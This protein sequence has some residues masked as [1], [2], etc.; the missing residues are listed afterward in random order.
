M[1]NTHAVVL[2]KGITGLFTVTVT[3]GRT[4]SFVSQP[5]GYLNDCYLNQLLTAVSCLFFISLDNGLHKYT[6]CEIVTP[7]RP[8]LAA[9][10]T[11]ASTQMS[12]VARC[13]HEILMPKHSV[14][15]SGSK[16][17][18]ARPVRRQVKGADDNEI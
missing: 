16:K 3:R 12:V 18:A 15:N 9:H 8:A 7:P 17:A 13:K 11:L 5:P 1:R 14:F 6:H 10:W 4:V 2:N